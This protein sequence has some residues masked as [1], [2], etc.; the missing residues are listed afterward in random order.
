MGSVRSR[1]AGWEVDMQSW[2]FIDMA[3]KWTCTLNNVDALSI[4]ESDTESAQ[5]ALI[6]K[7]QVVQLGLTNCGE[8]LG[9]FWV[10]FETNVSWH[11]LC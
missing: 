3:G 4:M 10:F 7:A 8:Q 11:A 5:D 9:L 1:E 6:V 2:K